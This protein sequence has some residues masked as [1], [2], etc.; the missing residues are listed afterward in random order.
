MIMYRD[1]LH[2]PIFHVDV[3]DLERQIVPREDVSTVVAELDIRDRGYDFGEERSS[4]G[5]FLF[6]EAY[7]A[8]KVSALG[9]KQRMINVSP[10]CILRACH[11][12]QS[13]A[14]RLA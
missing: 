11:T 9:A 4:R 12:R 10:T 5:I 2:G 1:R 14:C 6:F 7:R 13:P 3:P 8:V